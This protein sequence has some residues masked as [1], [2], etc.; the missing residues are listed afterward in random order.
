MSASGR[1]RPK[2]W[3]VGA[4]PGAA[5]LLTFRAADA[6]ASADVIVWAGSLVN[7]DVLRHARPGAEI[8]D[9]SGLTLED[10]LALYERALAEELVVARLHSGDPSVYG[11]TH[12]QI[13][14]CEARGLAFEVVP[15]VSSLGAAAAAAGLELTVPQV[16]QSVVLTRLGGR[17]P[18]PEGEAVRS[19][20]AHRTTMAVFLSAA[21]PREL[22]RE[23]EAGYPPGTPCVVVVRATWPD[24][25]V[26]R[27]PLG[28]LERTIRSSGAHR[29]VLVI[30]GPAL[31]ASG[32]R[33]SLYDPAFGH[34]FR[35]PAAWVEA[36]GGGARR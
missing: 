5:D 36:H 16:A 2:V 33:S 1:V 7:P 17:T 31:D 34:E 4:G 6:I 3:F 28:E 9:S 21:R 10:V 15:G 18:M 8:H 12:E 23:L 14:F 11:A 13:A 25:Q 19:F 22:Q 35:R 32:T 24:E 30:V 27:C 29:S 26:L 20:A